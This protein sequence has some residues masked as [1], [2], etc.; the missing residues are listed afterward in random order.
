MIFFDKIMI[1]LIL[2]I[3]V[4]QQIDNQDKKAKRNIL[5]FRSGLKI[6]FLRV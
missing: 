4:Y 5:Y 1:F 3:P 6:T 2:S